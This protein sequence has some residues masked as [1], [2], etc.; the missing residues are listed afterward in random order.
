MYSRSFFSLGTAD[1][2]FFLRTTPLRIVGLINEIST[3][4][5]SYLREDYRTFFNLRI[6]RSVRNKLLWALRY[7]RSFPFRVH[8]A[9]SF[10]S[11]VIIFYLS[12]DDKLSSCQW[13]LNVSN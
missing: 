2:F 11:D 12:Q 1:K 6:T 8:C 7:D 10:N 5:D 3:K 4:K 13:T 9:Q